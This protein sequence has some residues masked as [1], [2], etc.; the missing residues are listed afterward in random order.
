MKRFGVFVV[1]TVLLVSSCAAQSVNNAQRII[2]TWVDNNTG[3]TWVFNAN[4][5]VSGTD[6]DGDDFQYKFGF[7]DTKL[8]F[9]DD[10]TLNVFNFSI[11]SD[12]RTLIL[13]MSI[14]SMSIASSGEL[15]LKASYWFTK[16]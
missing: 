6:E 1:L 16:K 7:T 15:Y 13:E 2:G 10:S 8:V 9:S 5:T 14:A 4:G 11:S 3:K 12:G